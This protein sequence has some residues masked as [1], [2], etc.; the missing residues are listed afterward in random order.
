MGQGGRQ[1][2]RWMR[3]LCSERGQEAAAEVGV[4]VIPGETLGS[5]ENFLEEVIARLS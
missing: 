3:K 5:Q 2:N 1:R 4:G